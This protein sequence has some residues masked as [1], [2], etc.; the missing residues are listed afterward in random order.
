[1]SLVRGAPKFR[2]RK[3]IRAL[4]KLLICD[5][6]NETVKK[7]VIALKKFGK[8]PLSLFE[9]FVAKFDIRFANFCIPILVII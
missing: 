5:F 9:M 1:M 4:I 7:E 6:I 2:S 3:V 8:F